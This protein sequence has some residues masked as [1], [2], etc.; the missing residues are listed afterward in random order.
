MNRIH[1]AVITYIRAAVAENGATELAQA[2][3]G[4]TDEQIARMMFSNLRGREEARGLRLTKFGL[5][6]MKQFFLGY[7][8]AMP[9]GETLQSL[10]LLY[11]DANAKMPYYCS[12]EGFVIYDH[13]LGIK[14]KL[15]GGRV[16]TLI[17]MD[18]VRA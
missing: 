7:E 4:L 17:E 12:R 11:L 18:G 16:D 15:A 5:A 6:V 3:S 9:E 2:I 1:Q 13:H 8:V 14:L 10:H